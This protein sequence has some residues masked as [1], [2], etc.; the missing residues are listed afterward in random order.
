MPNTERM[1]A[2]A[3]THTMIEVKLA[4]PRAIVCARS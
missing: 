2:A 3:M 4:S 1:S